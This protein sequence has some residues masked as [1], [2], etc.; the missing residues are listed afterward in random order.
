M[1]DAGYNSKKR[2]Q[3]S[4]SPASKITSH[5]K[6]LK[7]FKASCSEQHNFEIDLILLIAKSLRPMRILECPYFRQ[8]ILRL[9]PRVSFP[10][11]RKLREVRLPEFAR[12]VDSEIVVPALSQDI[13]VAVT[14][15]LWMSRKGE[16]LFSIIVHFIDNSWKFQ[17]FSIGLVQVYSQFC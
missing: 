3:P 15:D 9:E 12:K 13:S 7:K 6:S 1:N 16:D 2:K 11:R 5:F 10:S 17:Q 8:T 14:L 4:P